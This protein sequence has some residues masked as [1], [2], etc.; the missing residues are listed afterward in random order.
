MN[1]DFLLESHYIVKAL[2]GIEFPITKQEMCEK[3]GEKDIKTG[4][5]QFIKL[6]DILNETEF[7]SFNS[8]AEFY[9]AI[10]SR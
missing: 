6:K 4:Y 1:K 3:F 7:E 8:A 2:K 9:S 5:N 10:Y